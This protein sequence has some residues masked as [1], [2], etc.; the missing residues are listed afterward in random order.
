VVAALFTMLLFI[1][2]CSDSSK[3]ATPTPTFTPA[4]G[5]YAATQNVTVSDTDQSAVLYCTNDGSTPTASSPQCANPIRVSQSQTLRTIAIASGMN[6]SAIV[7]AAYTINASASAP[8]ITGIGPATGSSAGGTSVTIAGTNFTGV[9]AVNFGTTQA[10]SFTVN[11][12]T[13]ITA[14][15]PAGSGSVHI[16]VVAAGGTSATTTEDLFSYGAVPSITG[17][18]PA[19]ATVGGAAFTLTVSGDNFTSDAVVQWNGAT[20]TTTLVSSTQLTAA[21]PASLLAAAGTASVTVTESGGVSANMAFFINAAAPSIVGISPA[22]G[23]SAG[24]TAVNITGTNFTGVSA[25]RF[26]AASAASFTVNS[27]NSITAVSPAGSAG[28]VDIQ[29]VTPSGASATGVTDQF[30]YLA[31]PAVTGIN[32]ATGSSAGG[33]TVTIT[34]LN[35]TGATAVNFGT[36]AA[37]GFT[38][39]SSTSITAVSPPGSA[40]TV[41]IQVVTPGGTSRASGADQFIYVVPVPT[42]TGLSVFA[43]K[44]TGGTTVNITGTNFTGAT[45]VNFGGTPALSFTVNSSTS[46]TAVTRAESASTVDVTVVTQ[47]GTSAIS[48]GDQFTFTSAPVVTRVSPLVGPV[49]GG[50]AVTIQGENLNEATAVKFGGTPGTG[51][52]ASADGSTISATSPAG[53]AGTVDIT[54]VSPGGTSLAN[55]ADQFTYVPAPTVSGVKPGSGS[56]LGGTAVTITGSNFTGTGYTVAAVNFG[57]V[58]ATFSV[59]VDGSSISATSPAGSAGQVDIRVVTPGGTSAITS[60]DQFTYAA[61]PVVTGVSPVSGVIAGGTAVT[62]TGTNF[63]EVSAVNFGG[64]AATYTVNSATSISATSPA[65]GSGTVDV[66][67]VTPYGTSETGSAD[68]QFTYVSTISGVVLSGP[69][70]GTV[71]PISATVQLYAAGT[72]G[73]GTGTD[74]PLKIGSAVPTNTTT[75][76]FGP[77][78]FDCSTLPKGGDQLYLVA[79]GTTNTDAVLM[80]ALGSC[81]NIA[82][83]Y[84]NGVTIN[85][86]T[87]IASAFAL[88]GFAN[89]DTTNAHGIDIGAPTGGPS[90]NA[91]AGWKSTGPS[92]CNYTGLKNAFATVTNLVDIPSGQALAVTPAYCTSKPC[93]TATATNTTPIYATS[94]VPQ[95]RINAMANALAACANPTTGNSTICGT[96]LT[97]TTIEATTYQDLWIGVYMDCASTNLNTPVDTLQAA[98]NIAHFPGDRAYTACGVDVSSTAGIYSLISATNPPYSP[99][100][101]STMVTVD[102]LRS[103]LSLALIFQGGGLG[104]S[105][106]N[107]LRGVDGTPA[108]TGLAIDANGNVWAPTQSSTHGSVVVLN[109]QGAPISA[110][111]S[112]NGYGGYTTGVYNPQS[113]AIDQNGNAW[114][115]NSPTSGNHSQTDFGSL[116]EIQLSGS[117]L[118]LTTLQNEMNG[119]ATTLLTPSAYGLAIDANNNV[120]VSSNPKGTYACG[121]G[122]YGGSIL[123]FSSSS[124]ALTL[125]NGANGGYLSY[126]DSS[127]PTTLAFDE[128]GL[129]WTYDDSKFN[130]KDPNRG[131]L[132]LAP[133]SGTVE[134]AYPYLVALQNPSYSGFNA[135][136]ADGDTPT[137]HTNMAIDSLGDSWFAGGSWGDGCMF[138]IPNMT[139]AGS[140][141]IS[142]GT[143]GEAL[144]P[145]SDNV[146]A[147]SPTAIDGGDNAWAIYTGGG[148]LIGY[149]SE[150]ATSSYNA[151][152]TDTAL[153]SPQDVG[154]L[155]WGFDPQDPS[156]YAS[157]RTGGTLPF[158]Q[159]D[160][161]GVDGSGNLWIASTATTSNV[162]SLVGSQLTEFIGIAV[163]V[164]T[165]L[166]TALVTGGL[167]AKP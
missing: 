36:T 106:N 94:I 1:A 122:Q 103:D 142:S 90:C 88:A 8:T 16:T 37:A 54:V 147:N 3:T 53:S 64:T 150:N 167:G 56:T 93:F 21:V 22:Q 48:S 140:G 49:T 157:G 77:I 58:A 131:V 114:I 155:K 96:L 105:V 23:L 110:A 67:V 70:T 135:C 152:A 55:S 138:V 146:I 127:C 100:V 15:S 41:D 145:A 89:A 46:I 108:T 79:S 30:T 126:P 81:A 151:T 28:T 26:G 45:A 141:A 63:T 95:G 60:M 17:L 164:Q 5:T 107:N 116:S 40:G 33:T 85:E 117:P 148:Y 73:Y 69:N 12:S 133:S 82:T 120:W 6:S 113:I 124:G 121:G 75:G 111:G 154:A 139:T 52:S 143:W 39:N 9:T 129:L 25:V 160:G 32:P 158:E 71:T 132:Q 47:Y 66:T 99:T 86:A 65:G 84:P 44:L 35:L 166:A 61:P 24:G 118:T 83:A 97:A 31:P 20:L 87:T 112:S 80:T 101:T 57:S 130:G 119:N 137:T 68:D 125:L 14:V 163:P 51:V 153:L 128:S 72:T 136:V 102:N 74:G 104:G 91:D 134:A 18:S 156:Q 19:S 38:V 123:E 50:T 98:L 43:G 78:A 13:S 162:N 109:N 165:P 7:S 10:A 2:G 59:S 92:T 161:L 149:S 27:A 11:S 76:V 115:G 144:L 62:I 4:A 159:G 29:V 42:I 34:G